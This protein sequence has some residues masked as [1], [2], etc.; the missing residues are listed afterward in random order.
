M[1]Q[2]LQPY[3][4]A[5]RSIK[6]EW[7]KIDIARFIEAMTPHRTGPK[8][9]WDTQYMES[10]KALPWLGARV[11]VRTIVG[12]PVCAWLLISF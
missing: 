10:R 9:A 2:E 6:Q 3:A 5:Q 1:N 8:K 11:M 12:L 4:L 7:V